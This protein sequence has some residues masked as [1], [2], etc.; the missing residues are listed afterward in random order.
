MQEMK[1]F[2]ASENDF[3]A[4]TGTSWLQVALKDSLNIGFLCTLVLTQS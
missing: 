2:G 4:S 1:L 3:Q